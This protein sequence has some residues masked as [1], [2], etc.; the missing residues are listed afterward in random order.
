MNRYEPVPAGLKRDEYGQI[1]DPRFG[2]PPPPARNGRRDSNVYSDDYSEDEYDSEIGTLI[3]VF[4]AENIAECYF[5]TPLFN[6]HFSGKVPL[7]FLKM[8]LFC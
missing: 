6:A 2:K 8:C 1:Y 7:K 3:W 5:N 4:G